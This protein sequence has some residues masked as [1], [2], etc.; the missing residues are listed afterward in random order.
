MNTESTAILPTRQTSS[1]FLWC[2]QLPKYSLQE[3]RNQS[4]KFTSSD[5]AGSDE[6]VAS[7]SPIPGLHRHFVP[8]ATERRGHSTAK[9][10]G[11]RLGDATL[12]VVF[13]ACKTER[14][15]LI[16]SKYFPFPGLVPRTVACGT[17]PR[18]R[19]EST[20]TSCV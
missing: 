6:C 3:L 19:A 11:G 16:V 12:R 1:D 18:W 13:L 15:L 8:Q 10:E 7:A 17:V 14:R 20:S 9:Y 2:C 4:Q 5:F